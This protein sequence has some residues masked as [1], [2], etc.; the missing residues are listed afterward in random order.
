MNPRYRNAFR[1]SN[2][3]NRFAVEIHKAGY[4]TSPTYSQNLIKLMKAYDLYRF[5]R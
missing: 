2:D 1:Y 4:A 5:D 3:P